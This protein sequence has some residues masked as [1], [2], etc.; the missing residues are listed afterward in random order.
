MLAELVLDPGHL[1]ARRIGGHDE[2]RDAAFAGSRVGHGEHDHDPGV[3]PRGDELFAAVEYVVIAVQTG[4][5]FQA[6]GIGTGLGFGQRESTEHGATGQ[7]LEEALFLV[8]I[9]VIEDRHATDRVVHAHDGR[10]GTVA[11]GDFFQGH[12]VGQ[13]TGI[14][15][16]P[17]LR[18]QHAEE[19]QL[20]HFGDGFLGE[21]VFTVPLGGEGF[22]AFLGKIPCRVAYLL[23]FVIGDHGESLIC[24]CPPVGAGLPANAVC[25]PT[26][27]STDTASS[28]A[29]SLL[30]G[31]RRVSRGIPRPWPSLRRRRCRS[32]QHHA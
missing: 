22:Q 11:R 16:A 25:H 14:A 8:G 19:A 7:G 9:A 10:A 18:H 2:R 28:R 13:V 23:L 3:L 29:S 30:Q 12:G 27:M 24:N 31:L 17:L 20:A 4:T 5:G 26:M 21:A 15:T 32:L 1:V 6:A